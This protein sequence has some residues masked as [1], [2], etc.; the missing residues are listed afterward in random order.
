VVVFA[1]HPSVNRLALT[2]AID[3]VNYVQENERKPKK[4]NV[5]CGI[6]AEDNVQDYRDDKSD[7]HVDAREETFLL[8]TGGHV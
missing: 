5:R 4:D 8:Q 3:V 7:G 6:M 2:N 1:Y